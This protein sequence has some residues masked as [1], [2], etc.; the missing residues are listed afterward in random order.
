MSALYPV[1][2]LSPEKGQLHFNFCD[3]E[4]HSTA[5]FSQQLFYLKLKV[6]I[7]LFI[8]SKYSKDT[9]L[10]WLRSG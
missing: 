4:T 10:L 7:Q 3:K 5:Q 9:F 8:P 1:I 2:F 6:Y